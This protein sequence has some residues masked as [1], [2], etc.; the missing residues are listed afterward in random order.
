MKRLHLLLILMVI[1]LGIAN[2]QVITPFTIRKTVT[3]KGGILYLSNT[4]SRA[5]PANIVQNEMPPSG[6]GYD[7]NYT[8]DYV[9]IDS[10]P[11]T[12]MS[13]SDQLNLPTCTEITWAGLYWGADCS[14]GDEN[15]A[16]RSQVKLK[17]NSGSYQ[18]LTADYFK[19]NTVGYKTY[20]CFKDITSIVQAGTLNDIYTVANVA[21][22][23]AGKNLF[24]GW[25]IVVIYKDNLQTMR[26]LTVFDGLANVGGGGVT[27]V[28]IPISGFQTPLS[29]PINFELGLVIYDGDRSLTGDQLMFKG[30]SAFVNLSDAIHPTSDMFNSTISK[31]GVLTP[32][33]NPSYNNNL[34]YDANIFVPNN[35]TKNYIGNNAVSGII[36]QTTGGE[37]FLTQVVT[38]A[39]DVYEPDLRSAVRVRNV[40]HP[41]AAN[42]SPGDTLE[43]TVVGMNIGSDPSINTYITDTIEGN[44]IYV[45][46][47]ITVT[48][49]PNAGAK[50]DAVGDDQA[51]Y[52]AAS[53][54]VKVRVGTSANGFLGGQVNNSPY[55]T[56]STQFKFKVRV[57]NDCVYLY[58]D[59]KIDNSAHM[60]G[61]GNVSGNTYDNASTPGIFNQYGCLI[62]GATQTPVFTGG[63]T[64]PTMTA[65]API[66]SGGTI[67]FNGPSSPAATYLWTGPNSFSS[68]L[69]NPTIS[70]VTAA[71]AGTYTGNL[72]I[73]GTGCHFIYNFPADINIANAGAD[74]T[75]TSTCGVTTIT[76][77]G[78]N[79]AGTSGVWSIVSGTGGGFGVGNT[80]TTTLYNTTFNGVSGNTYTLRWTLSSPGCPTTYDDVVVTFNPGISSAVLSA[81]SA[82]C[83]NRL[84][85]AITGGTSPYTLSINN[86]VGTV[87]NYTSGSNISV[88]PSLTTSY[89]LLSVTDA[90]GCTASS[91][92]GNPAT[93]TISNTMGTGVIT[94]SLNAPSYTAGTAGYN[95]CTKDSTTTTSPIWST[96]NN[97][98]VSDNAY[99][100]VTNST[101]GNSGYIYFYGFG[102]NIPTNATIDGVTVQVEKKASGTIQDN[103]ISLV[104]FLTRASIGSNL[105]VSTTNWGTT[106]AVTTYGGATNM[107]GATTATLTPTIVNMPR[108]GIRY[109]VNIGSNNA[110]AYVDA[111][112]MYVNYHIGNN[113]YCDTMTRAGF[114]VSGFTNTTSINWTAPTGGTILSGQGTSSIVVG[115]NNLGQSGSY[116]V[117]ATPVNACGQG[118]PASLAIQVSDCAGAI[119]P[120]MGN[121]YWDINGTA[122]PGK[123]D[124]TGIGSING[125][126]LYVS[127]VDSSTTPTSNRLVKATAAVA[128]NGTWQINFSPVNST[129]YHFV[130]STT[131]YP[132]T[133][134]YASANPSL[135]ATGATFIGEV[136][137]DIGNTITGTAGV[138]DGRLRYRITTALTNNE[139]NLNFAI[140]IPTAPV[141][142]NDATTTTEDN[143]VTLN[144]VTNDND[145][146]G[147]V[148]ISTVDL[149]PA[150]AG[151]Q[152]SF[153]SVGKGTFTVNSS[154]VVT[155]TPVANYNGTVAIT[156]TVKDNDNL[157]SNSGTITITITPVNDPPVATNSTITTP[158]NVLYHF[159]AAD[160]PYTDVESDALQS[161]TIATLPSQGTLYLNGVAVTVGQ[162][163]LASDIVY[164]TYDPPVN[165]YGNALTTFTFK[166]N[167]ASL[168]TIA[169]TVT[170]NVTH[171]NAPPVAIANTAST[172][173]NTAVNISLL[174][175]DINVDGTLVN[176]SID[177]D[178][179]TAGTQSSYTLTG[180]G[181]FTLSGATLTF[182]PVSTFYGNVTTLYYT[183]D[184]SVSLT[185]NVTT[186]DVTVVPAGAPTAVN[187][188][189]STNENVS[190]TFS[191]T[192]NDYGTNAIN[193]ARVDLD[194]NSTGIQGAYYAPGQGQFYVDM[195]GNVTFTPDP[196]YYGTVTI[197]YTVKDVLGLVSNI[198]NITV[199]V[200]W[201]N[202]APFAID[203]A[204]TTNEDVPVTYTIVLN[205][206][207]YD[208]YVDSSKVD[209]DPLTAGIQTT[210]TVSGQGTYT[211]NALGVVTFTP[212]ANY[213]GTATPKSYTIKDNLGLVSD[214][215][216]I[217]VTVIPVNDPPTTVSDA[218]STTAT[219]SV[220]SVTFNVLTNDSDM[221]DAIDSTSVDLDPYTAG[222]Q[223]SYT[224]AGEGTYTVDIYGNV[225]F[226]YTFSTPVGPLTQVHYT[227][228]DKSG[229]TSSMTHIDIT[230][231][232]LGTPTAN[233]DNRTGYEDNV[234]S[235][236]VTSNDVDNNMIDPSTLALTGTLVT[237]NGTWSI[238]S[239][240][241][242]PG[243]VT[244]TPTANF[245]GAVSMTYTV[246][247]F[248][249]LTSNVGTIYLTILPV[250]DAPTFSK[251][252]NL[253]VCE[254]SGVNIVNGWASGMSTGPSNES[255]Q[256]LTFIVTNDNNSLFSTQPS[257]DAS[258]N[259]A[260]ALATGKSG[261]ANLSIYI[262]D[263]GDTVHAGVDMSAVQ[264]ATITVNA[265][266]TAT[267]S[268]VGSP[269]PAHG[270]AYAT[271]NGFSGGIFSADPGLLIDSLSGNI[272]LTGSTVDTF[273]VMYTMTDV[274]GCRAVATSSI[275]ISNASV[276]PIQF[277]SNIAVA[278]KS[279]IAINWKMSMYTEN[280]EF[281]I[282]HSADGIHFVK[283][284]R[285]ESS[286]IKKG[287]V[288]FSYLHSSPF[289]GLNYYRIKAVS[290]SN[291][292]LP[293][294][295]SIM[296]LKTAVKNSFS[297][298]PNPAHD[299]L[300]LRYNSPNVAG[301]YCEIYN[302]LNQLVMVKEFVQGIEQLNIPVS[303][304]QAGTYRVVILKDASIISNQL[305]EIQH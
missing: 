234:I 91:I 255:T 152:T 294:Y 295:S 178:P 263:N 191:V 22:D 190:V 240:T 206:Y 282:E 274:Y 106:D 260:F 253:S 135:G 150:T 256:T 12:F 259:L 233:D 157:T 169:G 288:E 228:N 29:G 68:T 103:R 137:N 81:T 205:D 126:Q 196:Y 73:T 23:V 298:Y 7:N 84:N 257:I 189:A 141:A 273:A 195:L 184:N 19:D 97:A 270:T 9:D 104:N 89:T 28:D 172:T 222:Q 44:A 121:V 35:S 33:R 56:D 207:D 118:T 116:N 59:N 125:T 239:P 151:T 284:A 111:V 266:P 186:I 96:I 60:V 133:T 241:N 76:L 212:V 177:L 247:D 15:F 231:L 176:S 174:S 62:S 170:I 213:N 34:G 218:R 99:T 208:G 149:D 102:F 75:G 278:Q 163:I 297:L 31:N 168:G 147:T 264:T 156:Y 3:Q 51:D 143:A 25:T 210:Y 302:S 83:N 4:A 90:V 120:I 86:G 48:Y 57:S 117:V 194:P 166:A 243:Y 254:N 72:Y 303:N 245:Y 250:N 46:N 209:L 262:K 124:G 160:F 217:I 10:D 252:T 18:T 162:T 8:N 16:T 61:T 119:I 78:N 65:N 27:T 54:V 204:L 238:T 21:V 70:N 293:V 107:W 193:V 285:I 45:P 154:G 129:T 14:T 276:L 123:V 87:S 105:T 40:T 188:N 74:A 32:L 11:T 221:D 251:G 173:Q 211:V 13:S 227:V 42:A 305:V 271:V 202:S 64:V 261:V 95:L 300:M 94:A 1:T 93:V 258:G 171:V 220:A 201:V 138:A 66:C 283:I 248:D 155:F 24:G 80:S 69:Q 304:M 224:V 269:Y 289:A 26:N 41:S 214:S 159:V 134:T 101:T 140:K 146:D 142:N 130:V 232:P 49:G 43:Y 199:V 47:S 82:N 225:T 17:V 63:C 291:F 292:E 71:N 200:N 158:E 181:T 114:T 113:A 167:D 127:M 272:T 223:T 281:E 144:I 265:L 226:T 290:N 36:R 20:H 131:N 180:Q 100:S 268:Y 50:T 132:T 153:T 242:Y 112:Q 109:R 164:L 279:G 230:I 179:Y 267:V 85:V 192:N 287:Q 6:T 236:D 183:V 53:K 198:A 55:G 145:V 30:A 165:V 286:Q 58:C 92:T 249:T 37:I 67:Q 197:P 277:I 301:M 215:G 244:F 175:N 139:N 38:S 88:T 52:I 77:G 136:N 275:I 148:T 79:P 98:F 115:F 5:T 110:V 235:F 2:A 187:D 185:S 128:S 280:R 203:D 182:T 108:F 39:I 237:A 161:I 296:A 219:A 216:L 229:A 122:A 299:N 246:K